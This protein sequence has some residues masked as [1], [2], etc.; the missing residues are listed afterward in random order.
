M[1]E[2]HTSTG[3]E[4]CIACGNPRIAHPI[5]VEGKRFGL[6]KCDGDFRSGPTPTAA[7]RADGSTPIRGAIAEVL[8]AAALHMIASAECAQAVDRVVALH[9]AAIRE[10]GKD[11]ARWDWYEENATKNGVQLS[12][13]NVDGKRNN[14]WTVG[15]DNED[16]LGKGVDARMAIDDAMRHPERLRAALAATQKEK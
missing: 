6:M 12:C 3:D 14:G 5:R 8:Q 2:R 10:N 13:W 11:K 15:L 9:L 1:S 4:L 7:E 16:N